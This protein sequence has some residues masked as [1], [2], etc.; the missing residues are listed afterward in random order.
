MNREEILTTLRINAPALEGLRFNFWCYTKDGL[1]KYFAC[2]AQGNKHYITIDDVTDNPKYGVTLEQLISHGNCS[3]EHHTELKSQNDN[4][5]RDSSSL[6]IM[7]EHEK[8]DRLAVL[9]SSY[10]EFKNCDHPVN[11]EIKNK[12]QKS[13]LELL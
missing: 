1:S 9:V 6:N 5:L 11:E 7:T 13:I 8:T 12:I 10:V 3:V 2:D 4:N